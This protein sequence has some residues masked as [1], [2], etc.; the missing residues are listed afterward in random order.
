MTEREEIHHRH[1][2]GQNHAVGARN[3]N[4]E[5]LQVPH[6]LA[7]KGIAAAHEDKDIARTNGAA[8]CGEFFF[9]VEPAA[10][11]LRDAGGEARHGRRARDIVERRIPGISLLS[12]LRFF[13]VPD[14]D[15]AR[16]Q[17]A[18]RNMGINISRRSQPVA[19]PFEFEDAIDSPQNFGNGAEGAGKRDIIPPPFGSLHLLFEVTLHVIEAGGICA[20]EREDRLFLV[21]DGKYRAHDLAGAVPR[22]KFIGDPRHYIPLFGAGVLC[23]VHENMVD[24]AIEFVEHPGCHGAC[25][26]QCARL[27]DQVVIVE[28]STCPFLVLE[29]IEDRDG[30]R[31]DGLRRFSDTNGLE[32]ADKAQDTL[33]FL[34]QRVRNLRILFAEFLRDDGLAWRHLLCEEHTD[35]V[36]DG[37]CPLGCGEKGME[38]RRAL[39]IRLRPLHQNSRRPAQVFFR[40]GRYLGEENIRGRA[41]LDRQRHANS[42]TNSFQSTETLAH[43]HEISALADYFRQQLAEGEFVDARDDMSKRDADRR[44]GRF[45]G[46]TQNR[47]PHLGYQFLCASLVEN[48]ELRRHIGFK[49]EAAEKPLTEGV[50]RLNFQTAG[51]FDCTCKEAAGGRELARSGLLAADIGDG[52]CQ[53]GIRHCRPATETLVE[54]RRHFCGRRLG[55]SETENTLGFGAS[56]QQSCDPRRQ[57][58]RLARAGIGRHPDGGFGMRGAPLRFV[59]RHILPGAAAHSLSSPAADHSFTRARWS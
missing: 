38:S 58:M 27:R 53:L 23:F 31:Y 16:I 7:D 35:I 46:A 51:R 3:R 39:R 2:L 10:N 8:F 47:V 21:T 30:N 12:L 9:V 32:P 57:G 17:I 41:G 49:G 29:S 44:F 13:Q 11:G 20:L 42:G 37:V 5:F 25:R 22:Q 33:L 36:V 4:I 54:T 26:E 59:G 19:G 24:A 40:D 45:A 18:M 50:D 28:Q 43:L 48:L 1:L 34:L 14:F 15:E 52:R 55:E 56:E 6:H